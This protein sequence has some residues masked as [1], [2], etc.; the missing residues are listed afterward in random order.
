MKTVYVLGA[1]ATRAVAPKVPLTA[2]LLPGIL[3]S[4]DQAICRFLY[5][6]Y[7]FNS[8]DELP[9]VEDVL[10]Q[11]DFAIDENRPLSPNYSVEYMRRLRENLIY[12]I[13][14]IVRGG[15]D[16]NFDAA[17]GMVEGFIR[18]LP[19]DDCIVSLN[20]DLVTDTAIRRAADWKYVNYGYPV[21]QAVSHT[22]T[23]SHMD[24]FA[25]TLMYKLHGSLNWLFCP[26]CRAVDIVDGHL[27]GEHYIYSSQ[28]QKVEHCSVCGVPYEPVIITP[29]FL[30]SYENLYITYMWRQAEQQLAEADQ[31][32]FVGY[33]MPDADMIL[34]CM[35]RRAYFTHMQVHGQKSAIKVIDYAPNYDPATPNDVYTRYKRLFGEISY[36][37]RG[38][39]ALIPSPQ[40]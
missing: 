9:P 38:F 2:D 28:Q 39:Q 31:I 33:S 6:F 26:L 3:Q 25:P 15:K 22:Q 23:A 17:T 27:S 37:P 1:G 35:F 14:E 36:D 21:R 40:S 8:I 10:T 18:A 32:V 12:N 24:E 30:K 4:A 34:R 11:I 29:S 7:R 13:C 16:I 19:Q 5:D 20:Y